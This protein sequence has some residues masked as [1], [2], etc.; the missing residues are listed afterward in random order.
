[1]DVVKRQSTSDINQLHP[2]LKKAMFELMGAL[3]KREFE[4]GELSC[5][6]K[7]S[8]RI[9]PIRTKRLNGKLV[10]SWEFK[11][12]GYPRIIGSKSLLKSLVKFM[13]SKKVQFE[14]IEVL[15]FWEENL[16]D[17]SSFKNYGNLV[18]TVLKMTK[19]LRY[20]LSG[21][22]TDSKPKLI[23]AASSLTIRELAFNSGQ[24]PNLK[25]VT[26]RVTQLLSSETAHT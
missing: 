4:I 12:K 6:L 13:K 5:P 16:P 19:N 1:M 22:I 26:I 23:V 20:D 21:R 8:L 17:H 7:L 24:L 10:S 9:C 15:P 2:R 11:I 18:D 14:L 3:G 25:E